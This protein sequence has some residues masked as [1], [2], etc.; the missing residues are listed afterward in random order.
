M[1]VEQLLDLAL[2]LRGAFAG[3]V[4][5]SGVREIERRVRELGRRAARQRAE[6]MER[7]AAAV[8]P[9]EERLHHVGNILR[10]CEALL[11]ARPPESGAEP[12]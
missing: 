11:A 9:L 4:P 10:E 3:G 2:Q 6:L 12:S 5:A 8:G 1:T 7:D